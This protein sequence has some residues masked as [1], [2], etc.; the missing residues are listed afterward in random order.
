MPAATI[1]FDAIIQRME[2]IDSLYVI[3]PFDVEKTFGKKRLKI[4]VWYDEVLYRG[5]LAK[6]DGR[7]HLLLNQKTR[8]QLGKNAGDTVHIRIQEDT[9]ERILETP[10]LLKDFFKK[11]KEVKLLFDT[12]SYT[13]RKEY[14]DWLASAKKEATLQNRLIKFKALLS[15]KKK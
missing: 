4:K 8:A 11:E 1:E 2:K 14:I 9:E 5:L 3:F 13:H 6:Y 15:A 10:P 12:L 7:Y